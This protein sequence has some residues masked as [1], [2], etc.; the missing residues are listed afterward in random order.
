MDNVKHTTRTLAVTPRHRNKHRVRVPCPNFCRTFSRPCSVFGVFFFC[1]A[2]N[3]DE[4]R[5]AKGLCAQDR[6]LTQSL[7]AIMISIRS[8]MP[9]VVNTCTRTQD[10]RL[11]GLLWQFSYLKVKR[12]TAPRCHGGH[13]ETLD[14]TS[15]PCRRCLHNSCICTCRRQ[16]H[17]KYGRPVELRRGIPEE[18]CR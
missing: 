18:Q 7:S 3:W 5:R 4:K 1:G 2:P 11:F 10:T 8:I 17:Q 12:H 13:Q 6:R 15:N 14:W 9:A 16:V